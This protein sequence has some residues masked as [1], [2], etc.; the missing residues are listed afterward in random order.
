M[1]KSQESLLF[2]PDDLMEAYWQKKGHLDFYLK[3]LMF[4]SHNS[5]FFL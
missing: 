4:I 2:P 5:N 3:I 1:Q